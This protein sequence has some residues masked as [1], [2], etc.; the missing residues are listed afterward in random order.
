[1]LWSVVMIFVAIINWFAALFSGRTPDTLHRFSTTYIR[2]R[3]HVYAF[4][5]LAGNPFPGFVGRPGSYPVDLQADPSARQNRWI[6]G[7]RIFLALPA[8]LLE[9]RAGRRGA[10]RGDRRVVRRACSRAGCPPACAI[11]S[12]SRCATTPS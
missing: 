9:Q 1:M 3:L 10:G 5:L 7:F 12:P 2:Y 6:T 8:A 4:V 11:W